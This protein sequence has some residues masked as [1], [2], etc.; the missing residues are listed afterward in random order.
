LCRD[1]PVLAN[2]LNR[3]LS[4]EITQE[5]AMMALLGNMQAQERV[6]VFLLSL[7]QRFEAR[8]YSATQ[9]MLRMTREEIGSYLGLKLETV[10][11][12]FSRLQAQGLIEIEQNRNVRLRDVNALRAQAN[13][14]YSP[15]SPLARNSGARRV[16][17]IRRPA[18]P[19]QALA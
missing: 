1:A 3:L 18:T 11:R 15:H 8:G 4:R 16:V 19:A 9:F 2:E 17:P 14:P 10:S 12:V 7:A 5:Q 13:P 6:R